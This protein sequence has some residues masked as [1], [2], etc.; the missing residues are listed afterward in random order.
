MK[1]TVEQYKRLCSAHNSEQRDAFIALACRE[2]RGAEH[3]LMAGFPTLD[4][5]TLTAWVT[6]CYDECF[7]EDIL[8]KQ[9]VLNYCFQILRAVNLGAQRE[10]VQGLRSYFRSEYTSRRRALEWIAFVVGG[11]HDYQAA[12]SDEGLTHE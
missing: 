8:E 4:D 5:R 11:A 3:R 6:T 7:S 9:I 10:F 2:W 1:L 12:Q